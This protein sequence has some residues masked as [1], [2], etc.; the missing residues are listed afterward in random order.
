M[1]RKTVVAAPNRRTRADNVSENRRREPPTEEALRYNRSPPHYTTT[2]T[3]TPP[4]TTP[5]QTATQSTT[6][7]HPPFQGA[8]GSSHPTPGPLFSLPHPSHLTRAVSH[9]SQAPAEGG[10]RQ[11]MF[12]QPQIL[13]GSGLGKSGGSP[14]EWSNL[15]QQPCAS[16]PL[17]HFS[18]SQSQIWEV[19]IWKS[20]FRGCQK[21]KLP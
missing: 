14:A 8:G 9:C 6:Q 11:S 17:P 10:P 15:V 20:P 1:S 19:P 4:H 3:P 16:P 2:S 18:H 13:L 12:C 21:K 7:H 5:R